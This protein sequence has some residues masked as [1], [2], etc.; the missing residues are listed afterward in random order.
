MPCEMCGKEVPRLRKVQIGGS[1]LEVCNDCAKFREDAP[2]EAPAPAP[3]SSGPAAVAEP[4]PPSVPSHHGKRK[5]ALSRGEMDLAEDYN[6]RIIKGRRSKDL[7]Q[8]E[9]AKRINEKKSVISRLETGEMRPSDRLIKK[10]EK[11]LDIKLKERM[12]YQVEPA[13][14]QVGSG[15]VTLGDL[16]KMEK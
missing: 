12:E 5:D 8:E 3:V 6:R 15:G 14:K 10:L 16:I 11:E 2:S 4:R 7:T 9:L 1:T 13:K